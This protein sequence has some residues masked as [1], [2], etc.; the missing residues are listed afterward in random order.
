VPPFPEGPAMCAPVEPAADM[1]FGWYLN[2]LVRAAAYRLIRS[3]PTPR[4][5][6]AAYACF[7]HSPATVPHACSRATLR[8]ARPST[9]TVATSTAARSTSRTSTSTTPTALAMQTPSSSAPASWQ[10][11]AAD[12]T[13][14]A[15]RWPATTPTPSP[16]ATGCARSAAT[17]RR[18][19]TPH[20]ARAAPRRSGARA[21][22][23]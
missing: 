17:V 15:L 9:P 22:T 19:L 4:G 8:S 23:Q 7:P 20:L 3:R 13:R 16:I 10:T 21:L 11:R 12:S 5:Q 18:A 1:P 14:A 2:H 6:R